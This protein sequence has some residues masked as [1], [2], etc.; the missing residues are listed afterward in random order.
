MDAMNRGNGA[1]ASQIWL[2][3]DA[4]SRADFAHNEGMQP[5]TSPDEV[6]KQ[7]MQHY[8]DRW[9]RDG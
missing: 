4:K 8:Q 6:K 3:M 5:N 9:A 1:Q 7:I 2:N